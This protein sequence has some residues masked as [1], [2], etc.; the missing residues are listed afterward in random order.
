[1]SIRDI[2]LII[3][4]LRPIFDPKF[5]KKYPYQ[6]ESN[7]KKLIIYLKL[8]YKDYFFFCIYFTFLIIRIIMRFRDYTWIHIDV[9]SNLDQ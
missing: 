8:Q 4:K 6:P 5:I 7:L 9:L 1:M 3:Y 2:T